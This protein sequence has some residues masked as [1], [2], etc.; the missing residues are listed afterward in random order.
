MKVHTVDKYIR[1]NITIYEKIIN[2][3]YLTDYNIIPKN[4]KIIF[5]FM[6]IRILKLNVEYL[7]ILNNNVYNL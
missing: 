7:L 3:D 2:T 5:L 6:L 4:S 1:L